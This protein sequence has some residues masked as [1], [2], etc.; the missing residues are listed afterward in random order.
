MIFMHLDQF[1]PV[2]LKVASGAMSFS[3]S[4]NRPLDDPTNNTRDTTTA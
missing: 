3:A 2:F 4:H 1:F